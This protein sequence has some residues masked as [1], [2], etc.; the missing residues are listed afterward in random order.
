MELG[1][2]TK[3]RSLPSEIRRQMR[4]NRVG[5][6]ALIFSTL[7][8][9]IYVLNPLWSREFELRAGIFAWGSLIDIGNFVCWGLIAISL[10][11]EEGK[12]LGVVSLLL[13]AVTERLMLPLLVV[14]IGVNFFPL[15][16]FVIVP[17][18]VV[19]LLIRYRRMRRPKLTP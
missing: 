2:R 4:I 19:A 14:M 18:I 17:L 15:L 8:C 10:I 1:L 9:V 16:P 13:L 11:A 12:A 3:I 7:T 6:A 5:G